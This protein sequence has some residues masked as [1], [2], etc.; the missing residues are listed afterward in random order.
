MIMVE[1][2]LLEQLV[3]FSK[4]GTL[5]RAA[6]EL[7]ITQPALSRSMKKLESAFGVPLFDREKSKIL[8]NETGKVAVAYA[9]KV[10]EANVE[11]V[12]RT[13]SFDRS[14]RT[15]VLGSCAALP[16]NTLMPTLQECFPGK[17]ITTEIL[18]DDRLILGLKKRTHQLAVLHECPLESNIFCQ[19]YF[20]E[21][22]YIMLPA[23]HALASRETLTFADLEGMRILAHGS[24][25]FWLD[26]CRENLKGTKLLIQDGI[27]MLRELLDSSSLPAFHSD[28]AMEYG[29]NPEGRISIPLTDQAAHVTY[30]LACLDSERA[31]YNSIF[32]SASS[33]FTHAH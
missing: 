24:S 26:R 20:D 3:T 4:Y 28:R 12:E 31:K 2:F 9:R 21:Q 19:R 17:A 25:G 7:H 23:D 33:T 1:I 15:I 11:M 27:D 6:E 22:L 5:S 10:L 32:T 13:V 8:L 18:P 30:Y 16:I 14:M 29:Y